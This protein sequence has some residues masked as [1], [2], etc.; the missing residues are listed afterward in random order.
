MPHPALSPA[1]DPLDPSS[2][3]EQEG[4]EAE[5]RQLL[6]QGALAVLLP[7]EDLE[8]A[9]LRTLVADVISDSILGNSIGGK[10]C[11]GWFIWSS[12]NKVVEV[13]KAKIEPR[14]TG[15]QIEVDTRSRLEKFGLLSD[16]SRDAEHSKQIR[17]SA[18]SSSFWRILQYGYLAFVALRFIIL[19]FITSYSQS[20]RSHSA[21]R[22]SKST[23]SSPVEKAAESHHR[24]R[25]ILDFSIF[26]LVSIFMDLSSS[27][28]W[29]SGSV[30]LLQHHLIHGPLNIGATGGI[31]DQ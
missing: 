3:K 21:L 11:E 25:P 19:G 24:P 10:V 17:R 2:A 28:P 4:H 6:V 18:F 12:I 5:Y 31:I 7:T 14:A 16:Q 9:C 29:L 22:T 20:P 13:V 26:P 23:E 27:M 8:N 30:A 1:P 15:E